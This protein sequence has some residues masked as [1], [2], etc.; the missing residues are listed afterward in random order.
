MNGGVRAGCRTRQLQGN[1]KRRKCA[2]QFDHN[3]RPRPLQRV[4]RIKRPQSRQHQ[5]AQAKGR[6]KCERD[7]RELKTEYAAIASAEQG[8]PVDQLRTRDNH[9]TQDQ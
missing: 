2:Q 4:T 7:Q 3:Q 9:A 8:P 1:H 6:G 5:R